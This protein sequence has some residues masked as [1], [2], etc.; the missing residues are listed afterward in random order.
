MSGL[1]T[2]TRDV[3]AGRAVDPS[4]AAALLLD[5]ATPETDVAGYLT[6][7]AVAGAQPT[8]VEALARVVLAAATQVPFDGRASDLVGTGGDGSGSVNISTLAALIAAASGAAVAKAGNRAATSRCGSADLLENLGVDID[9]GPAGIAES[10]R[11]SGFAF[12]LT[13]A[14]HPIVGK[15]APVRRRLGFPTLFNLTGPLTNPVPVDGQG[16]DVAALERSGVRAVLVTPAHQFPTGVVLSP[17]RRR[18]LVEWARRVDG[19]IIED[20]YDGEF[21][22]DLAARPPSL[23][24]LAP[25]HVVYGGTASKTLA[26]GLRLGWLVAPEGVVSDL[27]EVRELFD[28]GSGTV[29]QL[30]YAEFIETGRLDK[31]LRRV[32]ETYR[33]R[34][35]LVREYLV[36]SGDPMLGLTGAAAGLHAHLEFPPNLGEAEF[37]HRAGRHRIE[38]LGASYFCLD[39]DDAAPGIVVGYAKQSE[40][41]LMEALE[42][43]RELVVTLARPSV[44]Q[45]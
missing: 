35:D 10:L 31:H 41:W 21:W 5:P 19:L 26:P 45:L 4:A 15:L 27:Q 8:D 1:A 38:L 34:F 40:A 39:R 28:L 14:V 2:L 25:D 12:V 9:P 33:R 20:D 36:E 18:A 43:L 22:Y 6:A 29:E 13:S 32:R 23:Q 11:D 7:K 24:R 37:V 42:V 16:I 17:D 3:G 44:P 30:A